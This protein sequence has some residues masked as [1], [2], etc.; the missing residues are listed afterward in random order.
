MLT[1]LCNLE[2][3][4]AVK[5]HSQTAN[6][7]EPIENDSRVNETVFQVLVGCI[8]SRGSV[9]SGR[10]RNKLVFHRVRNKLML[11]NLKG[12]QLK[13]KPEMDAQW[14]LLEAKS[15]IRMAELKVARAKEKENAPDSDTW[16]NEVVGGENL[17]WYLRDCRMQTEQRFKA[18]VHSK[19]ED[20]INY[21]LKLPKVKLELF[22]SDLSCHWR[23]PKH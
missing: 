16:K 4:L 21:R 3:V 19:S 8:S 12:R 14:K 22:I 5:L 23:F 18:L 13:K 7:G 11:T 2:K 17:S 10:S 20:E 1:F 9:L 6:V 15:E